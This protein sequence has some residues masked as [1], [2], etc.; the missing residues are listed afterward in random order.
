MFDPYIVFLH[1]KA[2][3]NNKHVDRKGFDYLLNR[4]QKFDQRRENVKFQSVH[5]PH[6]VISGSYKTQ[7]IK[8][9]KQL[10]V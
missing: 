8:I 5:L 3:F 4:N 9:D 6:S 1:L 7:C 10:V 2:S